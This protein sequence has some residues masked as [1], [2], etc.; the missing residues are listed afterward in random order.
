MSATDSSAPPAEREWFGQPRGLT[1]LFLTEMWE[2]FSFVGM[3]TMLVY[4]MTKQLLFE[5]QAAS[6]TYGLYTGF[7][8]LTPII[9]GA[10]ADRLLGRRRAV[11]LGGSIMAV[12]HFLMMFEGLFLPALATVAIGN[13]FFLPSLPSQIPALY[14]SNDPRRQSAYSVYYMGKNLGAF[15]APLVCG[16]LGEL[17]GWH[18]GFGAAGVGMCLG[19]AIYILGRRHLPADPPR[20]A[21]TRGAAKPTTDMKRRIVVLTAVALSVVLFRSAYEQ[22]GNSVSLWIDSGVDRSVFG[23]AIPMTWFQSINPLLVF[24]LTPILIVWWTGK[25]KLGREPEPLT[26]M[27]M[28][29]G[30]V[31]AAYML[32]SIVSLVSTQMDVK[33][34]WIWPMLFFMLLTLG[35]LYI[36]P[37]GLG[38]FGRV[39]PAALTATV[40]SFWYLTSFGGNF[41]A[42]VLGTLWS[43]MAPQVFFAC[44]ASV[45]AVSCLFLMALRG[46]ARGIEEPAEGAVRV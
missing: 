1:I 6:L 16:T 8:Y 14:A 3:R 44:I 17:V 35:E 31:A 39:A 18:W 28:G 40:I 10:I 21:L 33:P 13:G 20:R 24:V 36:L 30:M 4:Y 22:T 2:V 38:L 15:L 25:A 7:V 37:I 9:G 45:A 11:I 23:A 29:A 26:K 41:L 12:G 32:L 27:A 43:Q 46:A 5:Q 42:G 19:L 34:I